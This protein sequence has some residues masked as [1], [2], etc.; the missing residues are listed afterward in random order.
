MSQN[1]FQNKSIWAI[2]LLIVIALAFTFMWTKQDTETKPAITKSDSVSETETS[3][4][5]ASPGRSGLPEG[6]TE[7]HREMHPGRFEAPRVSTAPFGLPLKLMGTVLRENEK[8]SAVILNEATGEE[9]LYKVGDTIESMTLLKIEKE[10]VFLEKD[11]ATQVL[12]ITSSVGGE[13]QAGEMDSEDGPPFTGVA[14]EFEKFEP[15]VVEGGPPVDPNAPVTE[16]P[17]FEPIVVEGGPPVD[18]NMPIKELPPFEPITSPTGPPVNPGQE[19]T[20]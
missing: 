16:L 12:R 19:Q 14:E 6:A 15:V 1:G 20:K 2:A 9:G 17:H 4:G 3:R 13:T 5:L 8:S 7:V 10:S 18:P 11:G